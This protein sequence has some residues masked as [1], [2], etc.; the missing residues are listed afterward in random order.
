MSLAASLASP[1]RRARPDDERN[2]SALYGSHVAGSPAPQIFRCIYDKLGLP[3]HHYDLVECPSL[4]VEPNP[5]S[6]ALRRPDCLGTCVT[7]PL[8]LQAYDRV[9]V[10]TDEALATG[11]INTTFFRPS[12]PLDPNSPPVTVGTNTDSPACRAVLLSYL[13][14][15]PSPF[16]PSAPTCFAPSTRAAALAIGG[17]GA[18]RAAIHALHGLGCS[19]IYIVNRDERETEGMTSHFAAAGWDV[20]PLRSVDEARAELD[21]LESEGGRVVCGVGAIPCVEPT[22][23]GEKMVYDVAAMVFERRYRAGEGPSVEE[24]SLALPDRPVFVDMAYKPLMTDLRVKAE[25]AGWKSLCGTEVVLENCFA[26][27]HLFTG[28]E[29]PTDVRQSA[30]ELLAR[31]QQK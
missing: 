13:L 19:P 10:L 2:S 30:R 20:R 8:K 14:S 27:C 11:C 24:G 3:R 4:E 23:E 5:W 18:T 25:E 22:T 12:D 29:V 16:P 1:T 21:R 28:L 17:G 6:D 26:Q 9:D 7:M 31:G 15:S